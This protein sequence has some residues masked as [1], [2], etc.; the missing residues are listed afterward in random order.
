MVTM[1]Q[2]SR[3]V[4]RYLEAMVMVRRTRE[5][6][7]NKSTDWSYIPLQTCVC[8]RECVFVDY[9]HMCQSHPTLLTFGFL[10]WGQEAHLCIIADR[11]ANTAV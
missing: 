7:L 4:S 6:T 9:T 11:N 8:A 1:Q 2:R 5:D 10:N 3:I